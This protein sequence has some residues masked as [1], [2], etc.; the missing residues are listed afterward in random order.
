[1]H[2][3][4]WL[5]SGSRLAI[6]KALADEDTLADMFDMDAVR[7]LVDDHMGGRR[8]EHAKLC[9]LATFSMWRRRYG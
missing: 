7:A 8:N 3:D 5:R 9:A 2:Y 6:E 4:Q 1:V